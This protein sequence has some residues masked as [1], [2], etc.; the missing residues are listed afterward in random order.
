LANLVAFRLKHI[1]LTKFGE[2]Y[3]LWS[4]SL[5]RLLQPPTT[6]SLLDPNIL[7]STLLSNILNKQSNCHTKFTL[8]QTEKS[9][10]EEIVSQ[11]CIWFSS[12]R[13][14]YEHFFKATLAVK[15]KS[16]CPP[17]QI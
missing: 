6:S 8:A 17:P 14:G 10:L 11:V 15:P 4:S 3:N 16:V 1:T 2:A 12:R 9:D 13:Q 7:L 5:S